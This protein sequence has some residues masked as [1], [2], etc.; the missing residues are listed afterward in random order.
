MPHPQDMK[1]E[2]MKLMA[3]FLTT[4]QMLPHLSCHEKRGSLGPVGTTQARFCRAWMGQRS[5]CGTKKT[6]CVSLGFAVLVKGRSRH[7]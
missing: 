6:D 7:A 2:L 3:V 5:S 1:A 4:G